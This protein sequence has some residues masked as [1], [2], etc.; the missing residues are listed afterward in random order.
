[1]QKRS[2]FAVGLFIFIICASLFAQTQ[3]DLNAAKREIFVIL[4]VS[5]SMNEQ[6]RFTNV[7]DYLD[8]EVVDVLLKNGDDFNLVTFG[9]G[10]V[11]RFT[12]TISSNADR[13]SLKTEL[14]NLRPDDDYTDIGTAMEKLAEILERPEKAG[15]RRV[16]LFITDG[17]NAPP[18]G[19]KFSGVN[20]S[21]DERFRTL[22]E[23]ISRGSWF[24]YIIGIGGVTSAQEIAD[25]VPGSELLT[26]GS[27][28]SGM[29]FTERV[30]EQEAEEQARI[31]EQ[32]RAAEERRIEE[33]RL[34]EERRL[35]AERNAG[36]IG[37]LR[38]L[39]ANIGIP[40]EV[41]ILGILLLLLLLIFIPVFF[42][43]A[44]KP[45]ILVI[46]DEKETLTKKIPP[47]GRIV[48]NST[49]A[50]LPS[51]GNESSRVFRIERGL[52]GLKMHVL[53]T[54]AFGEKS[55]YK[56]GGTHPLRG[57]I[58]LANGSQIKIRVR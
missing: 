5:G 21:L 58:S 55:P 10:A 20:I 2:V 34:E 4:D 41:L 28:L 49:A 56:K 50:I 6:N 46:G 3:A 43:R 35:E 11:E 7:Q 52:F 38:R 42:I 29:D 14:R 26:T 54:Q 25:L 8:R 23:R 57:V 47:F 24:F 40:L 12:R 16:I 36:F 30:S 19:S 37:A 31:E 18:P 48:F 15:I 17:L 9:E 22:G 45:K 27:D 51:L 32:A 44:F 33:L 1:M 13:T 39:A 53:E